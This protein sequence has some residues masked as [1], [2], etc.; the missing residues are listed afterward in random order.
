[1]SSFSFRKDIQQIQEGALRVVQ[2]ISN[3]RVKNARVNDDAVYAM[4]R[5]EAETGVYSLLTEEAQK[6]G[7]PVETLAQQVLAKATALD[8]VIKTIELDRVQSKLEINRATSKDA[9][10]V[11]VKSIHDKATAEGLYLPEN[12]IDRVQQ[13]PAR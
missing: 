1:M 9:I 3:M 13:P 8:D 11:L 6:K 10:D 7:I 5:K 12:F 4:K 2:A